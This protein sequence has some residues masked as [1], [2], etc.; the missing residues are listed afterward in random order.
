MSRERFRSRSPHSGTRA[1]GPGDG[2]FTKPNQ[3]LL[4]KY[5]LEGRFR[6]G[7]Y[8]LLALG[9]FPKAREFA[10]LNGFSGERLPPFVSDFV[11]ESIRILEGKEGGAALSEVWHLID[12]AEE[13]GLEKEREAAVT[14]LCKMLIRSGMPEVAS[15]I[16]VEMLPPD[17]WRRLCSESLDATKWIRDE[18]PWREERESPSGSP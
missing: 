10:A 9:R 1:R 5:M 12:V 3:K 4:E 8:S 11:S 17:V 13:F 6:T 14:G 18:L 16:A 2:G 15:K 7:L